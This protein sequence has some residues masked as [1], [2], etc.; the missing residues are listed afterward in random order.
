LQGHAVRQPV[1]LK[2]AMFRQKEMLPFFIVVQQQLSKPQ[3]A[4]H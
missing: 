3:K 1:V 2:K 4:T